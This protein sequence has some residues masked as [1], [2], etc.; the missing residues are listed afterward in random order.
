MSADAAI[1][2]LSQRRGM[3]YDPLVVDAFVTAHVALCA[4][5][6]TSDVP[7][8]LLASQQESHPQD[9][10]PHEEPPTQAAPLESLRLLARLAPYPAAPP[11]RS[12][13]LHLVD[14]LRAIATF[15]TAVIFVADDKSAGVDALFV[16]GSGEGALANT[17]IPVGEQLTGWVVAHQ[18][19]VWNSDAALDLA[20]DPSRTNLTIGSS[21]PLCVEDS[22][23]GALTLYG[24]NGEEITV[25]QRRALESLLPAISASLRDALE[26]PWIAIDARIPNI[27][28]AALS[29]MDS[30]LSHSR[31]PST[32][33]FGSALALSI[34]ASSV[35]SPRAHLSM[36]SAVRALVALLSPRNSSS[37]CVLQLGN[38][39]LL[40]CA[41]DG[42]ST[43]TLAHEVEVAKNSRA[44]KGIAFSIA[45][46]STPLELKDRVRRMLDESTSKKP[47]SSLLSRLN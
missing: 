37:R 47:L 28:E 46:I 12:V 25:G 17:K 30:L 13:C 41:L 4:E 16:Q 44:F 26:R 35:E 38:G 19:S 10:G 5:A 40:M 43:E 23:V 42:S 21:M 1:D 32:E 24:K 8:V 45:P 34:E 33:S 27:R 11:P 2:I 36:E 9:A 14:S 18:T 31:L 20:S 3:M 39:H 22:V 7:V 29:A 15:D 6:E